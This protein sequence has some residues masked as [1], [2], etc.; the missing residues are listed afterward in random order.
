MSEPTGTPV[1]TPTP[2][3][4]TVPPSTTTP[5]PTPT[6]DPVKPPEPAKTPE[7]AKVEPLTI[8]AIKPIEGIEFDKPLMEKF[9]GVM[10]DAALSPGDRANALV[11][12]QAEVM[13]QASSKGSELWEQTQADWQAK[14][15]SDPEIGGEKLEPLLGNISRLLTKYAGPQEQALRDVFALTGFGNHPEA[16]RF[17]GKIANELVKEGS[18]LS[19]GR[20]PTTARDPAKTLFPNQN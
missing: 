8:D 20:P 15:Q 19:T 3:P 16:I 14:A 2:N 1:P 12:L 10:N 9:V 17:L 11:A 18:M 5:T 13:K 6:P 4:A 7:P